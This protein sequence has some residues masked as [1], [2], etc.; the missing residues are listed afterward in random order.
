MRLT[1]N[2]QAHEYEGAEEMPLLW[3]LRDE[4]GLM[5]TKYGCL[6]A[7]CGSC[8]VH[9]NGEA[10]RSCQTPMSAVADQQVTTIEGL[11]PEGRHPVQVAWREVRWLNAATVKQGKLCRR[12][13]YSNL[14]LSRPTTKSTLPCRAICAVAGPTRA[15]ERP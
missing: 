7:A 10:V 2:G 15:S 12:R 5:G 8:T 3:F 14:R 6:V 4:I 13:R 9:V 11:D 1:I